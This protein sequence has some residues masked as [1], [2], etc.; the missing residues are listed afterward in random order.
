MRCEFQVRCNGGSIPTLLT[1]DAP[2]CRRRPEGE[3]SCSSEQHRASHTTHQHGYALLGLFEV[4]L[5]SAKGAHELN[6][7][8]ARGQS[9]FLTLPK[10]EEKTNNPHPLSSG[11][12][13]HVS[14]TSYFLAL[15]C[16]LAVFH[17]CHVPLPAIYRG[18]DSAKA[19]V[20]L[21]LLCRWCVAVDVDTTP[22]A[23]K[24]QS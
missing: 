2:Y 3:R 1:S 12:M 4:N 13:R 14:N 23:D 11:R 15:C 16:E 7:G 17:V 24:R 10:A 9:S 22:T 21:R 19:R 5:R 8:R 18:L 20:I 6:S